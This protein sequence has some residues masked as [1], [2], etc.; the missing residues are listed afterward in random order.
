MACPG[1]VANSY[2]IVDEESDYAIEGTAAHKLAEICLTSG[3]QPWE[4]IGAVLD[5]GAEASTVTKN[6]A[7]AVQEFVYVLE[8]WHPY[9]DR[10][11][12]NTWVEKKFHCPSIHKFFYGTSDFVYLSECVDADGV[13]YYV[14]HVWDYK[15]GAGI[16]VDAVKNA[17]LMYYAAGVLEELCMWDLVRSVVVHIFQPRAYHPS[18]PHRRWGASVSDIRRWIDEECVPAMDLALVS[19]DTYVGG[20]CIFCPARSRRCPALMAAVGELTELI[21]MVVSKVETEKLTGKDAEAATLKAASELTPEQLGRLLDLQ[22]L[23]SIV[24][25]A[26]SKVAYEKLLNGHDIPGV[27]LVN[28]TTYREW[29]KGAEQAAKKK[30]GTKC[31]ST[32]SF[33]SPAQL[34]EVPGGKEFAARWAFKPEGKM[35]V[36]VEGDPRRRINRDTKSLFSKKGN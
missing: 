18:G 4:Y 2:G 14:L 17:Q 29:K 31:L 35:T 11:Q 33:K 20:H 36:A 5:E 28:A 23:G 15:H 7:N 19:H 22:K 3:A 26:A 27:K 10:N 6:M 13:V 16:V 21:D 9:E 32:P 1:S 34:E 8:D 25:K 30:F 24:F 12:G